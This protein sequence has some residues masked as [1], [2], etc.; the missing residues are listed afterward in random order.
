M[1]SAYEL[2][3]ERLEGA[4]PTQELSAEQRSALAAIDE[5]Y[6][7]K[8]A[9]RELFLDGLISKAVASGNYMELEELKEQR[10]REVKK[11]EEQ[12]DAE[13]EKLRADWR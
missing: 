2:A 3:M 8:T 5:K 1:K 13:K 10:A 7:A 12:R 4:S 6:Q 11:F 9:E